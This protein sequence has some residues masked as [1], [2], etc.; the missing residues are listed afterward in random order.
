MKLIRFFSLIILATSVLKPAASTPV[1]VPAQSSIAIN[2]QRVLY[3]W[4]ADKIK[5]HGLT[6]PSE[7]ERADFA[8]AVVAQLI[9]W[10]LSCA[11]ASVP[12]PEK[13]AEEWLLNYY[14]CVFIYPF[15]ECALSA[16]IY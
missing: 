9:P 1:E 16:C 6:F 4:I 11:I 12:L 5:E 10:A 13:N 8:D 3:V 15:S 14:L 7:K 2:A